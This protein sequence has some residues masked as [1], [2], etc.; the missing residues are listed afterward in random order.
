MKSFSLFR[1]FIFTI[2]LKTHEETGKRR[3]RERVRRWGWAGLGYVRELGRTV[4]R[5][6]GGDLP[7]FRVPGENVDSS[8]SSRR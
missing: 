7:G 5:V 4:S 1:I 2:Y 8:Y 3:D 6:E